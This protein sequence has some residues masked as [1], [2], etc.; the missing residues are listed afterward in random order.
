MLLR[1]YAYNDQVSYPWFVPA[2]L[3]RGVINNAVSVGYIDDEGEFVPVA[4]N[5]GQRDVLYLNDINPIKMDPNAGLVVWGQKT[6]YPIDSSARTRVNVA[7]LINY[8]SYRLE[9]IV[10]PYFF[11]P[12]DV[13]TRGSV[14]TNIDSFLGELVSLRGV[15][16]FLVVCDS[17]NNTNSRIDRNELWIDIALVP[18]KAIEFIYIPVRIKSTGADLSA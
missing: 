12:N 3:Q 15:T 10:Q 18:T 4:L 13:K 1:T 2:G 16:D 14:K 7:R 17:S 9:V 8:I 5:Q 11:Q 6:R